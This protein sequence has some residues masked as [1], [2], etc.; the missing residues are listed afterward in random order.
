MAAFFMMGCS[1]LGAQAVE[2]CL[3]AAGR[4]SGVAGRKSALS[5]NTLKRVV[6]CCMGLLVFRGAATC[7]S[8]TVQSAGETQA[9]GDDLSRRL[10]V[11]MEA[12]KTGD[13]GGISHA[14]ERVIAVGLVE[15]A[16]LRLDE[17]AYELAARLCRESLEFEDTPESRLELAIV[18]LYAK[19][20]TD[21]V[22]QASRATE[23]EPRN[24]LGWNIK[25][26]ALL[27]NKDYAGAAAAL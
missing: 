24:A 7:Q 5:S 23:M 22:E 13:L 27:Q 21:A 8:R 18:S 1:G 14:S 3:V 9:S 20:P 25:G 15:M 10:E 26:E 2:K 16:K 17:G 6:V 4:L 12:R 11:A 19:K